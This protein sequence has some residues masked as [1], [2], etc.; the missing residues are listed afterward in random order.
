MSLEVQAGVFHPI[1]AAQAY[2]IPRVVGVLT[3]PFT[4]DPSETLL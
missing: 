4:T 3:G 2:S 1:D